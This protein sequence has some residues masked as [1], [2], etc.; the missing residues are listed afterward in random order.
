MNERIEGRDWEWW[1]LWISGRTQEWIA[2][3]AGVHQTTV[4]DGIERCRRATPEPIRDEEIRRSLA[5]L[6]DLRAGAVEIYQM[7]AVPV[8]VGK[9]GKVAVDP[10]T[11]RVV[12][13]YGGKLKALETAVRVDESIR[14]LL[15]LDAAQRSEVDLNLAETRAAQKAADE[16]RAR[17]EADG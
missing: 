3:Q 1:H 2:R 5:L 11:D 8:F 16:A 17:L 4:S 7:A 9:D 10:E 6:N 13:D 12:R 14:K 15:G